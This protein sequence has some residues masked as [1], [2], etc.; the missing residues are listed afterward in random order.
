MS[1]GGMQIL[2]EL[3]LQALLFCSAGE[4]GAA[5]QGNEPVEDHREDAI[6]KGD[7]LD[8]GFGDGHSHNELIVAQSNMN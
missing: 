7:C 1:D 4:I 3:Q 2:T 8:D 5:F 6:A